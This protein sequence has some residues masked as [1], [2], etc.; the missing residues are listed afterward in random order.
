MPIIHDLHPPNLTWSC[1]I[2]QLYE[3]EE[4]CLKTLLNKRQAHSGIWDNGGLSKDALV[5]S[6][7]RLHFS[8]GLG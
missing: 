8:V 3:L 2:S 1:D 6:K 7:C 4:D 5:V